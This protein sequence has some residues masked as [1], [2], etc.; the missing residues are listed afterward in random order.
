MTGSVY[1]LKLMKNSNFDS[2]E[3]YENMVTINLE[4][5][6]KIDDKH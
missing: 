3:V 4:A 5:R 2:T 1:Q 6:I